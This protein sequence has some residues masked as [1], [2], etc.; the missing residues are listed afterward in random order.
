[1]PS[2]L[3]VLIPCKNE[4][5]NIR[6]DHFAA[7]YKADLDAEEAEAKLVAEGRQHNQDLQAEARKSAAE[8]TSN[9]ANP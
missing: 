8:T 7:I 9:G 1:M 3:T 2:Q 4:R 6:L 5:L